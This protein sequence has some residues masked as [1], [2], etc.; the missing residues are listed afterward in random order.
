M[1]R[2]DEILKATGKAA[3]LLADRPPSPDATSYDIVGAVSE[4]GI[5]LLFRPLD[6]LWGAAIAIDDATRGILVT[7][8]LDLHVQRFTLAHELGHILLEHD[9]SLDITIEDAG[10]HGNQSTP[11]QEMAA[12][13]FASELLAPKS[14]LLANAQRHQWNRHALQDPGN[15]YQ[16]GLRM[17][18]SFPAVCWALI[19]HGVLGRAL[20]EAM[21]KTPVK[22]TKLKEAPAELLTNSWAN[23]WRIGPAD[24]NTIIE[25]GPDDL[26]ALHVSDRV[27]AG[28]IWQ[29]AES[30]AEAEVVDERSSD[31]GTL[32]GAIGE[33][34]DRIL[35]LRLRGPG[36]HRLVVEHMRPWNRTVMGVIEV[37]VGNYGK[38]REGLP[39]R[40]REALLV[41]A[42]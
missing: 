22:A 32:E 36:R 31:D 33:D 16:L 19:T 11:I 9:T 29:L 34:T 2:R 25:A 21:L 38:E 6:K 8:K 26:F 40:I 39:R 15:V 14:L 10:K 23:I 30:G 42:S 20:V 24:S 12:N 4:L 1:N 3:Q 37:W 7:T 5:P 13:T 18:L 41:H 35:Y 28:Y 27:G 17:G